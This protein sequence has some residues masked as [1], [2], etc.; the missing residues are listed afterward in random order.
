MILK[1]IFSP[2][3]QIPYFLLLFD[4]IGSVQVERFSESVSTTENQNFIFP[5]DRW[6]PNADDYEVKIFSNLEVFQFDPTWTNATSGRNLPVLRLRDAEPKGPYGDKKVFSLDKETA[7]H[8]I[9]LQC[10][11]QVKVRK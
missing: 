11:I 10:F 6:T 2:F 8:Q 3:I 1:N 7:C 9:E 5:L 4:C